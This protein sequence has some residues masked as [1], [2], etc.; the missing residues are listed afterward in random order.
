MHTTPYVV[1]S[2]V[3]DRD[4]GYDIIGPFATQEEAQQWGMVYPQEVEWDVL[5]LLDPKDIGV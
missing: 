4:L 2:N 1:V 3:E 5:P